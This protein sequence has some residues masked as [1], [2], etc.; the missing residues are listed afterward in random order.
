M[1]TIGI[2]A[3]S[4][5][6]AASCYK[7][8]VEYSGRK[9]GPNE[10]PEILLDNPSFARILAAQEVRDW[11]GV[12]QI[13]AGAVNKLADAGAEFAVVPAN[14][15]HFGF[16]EIEKA[17]KIPVLNLVELAADEC[18]K[19]EFVRVAVLGVGVTMSDGLYEEALK[20][21]GITSVKLPD[22]ERKQIN[23][24]IYEELVHGEIVPDSVGCIVR[25]CERLMHR[26]C[27]AVVLACTEL[28]MVINRANSPLPFIDTTDLLAER[29]VELSLAY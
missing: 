11:D 10:H 13:V 26:G 14:S 29:A 24:I 9:L 1:K 16:K 15:A 12:V 27:D 7:K 8:I 21:R 3:V 5:E 25:I 18:V 19:Q 28:P 4:A 22:K 2:A 23:E 20:S 6:G 17:A